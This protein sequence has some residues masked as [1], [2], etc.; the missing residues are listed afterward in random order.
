MSPTRPPPQSHAS[1]FPVL[2]W[3][4]SPRWHDG[5]LMVR[6]LDRRRGRRRRPRGNER[7]GRVRAASAWA[8]RSTGCP[9]AGM[10]VTGHGTDSRR[11]PTEPRSRHADLSPV[12]ASHGWNEIVVDGRGNIYVNTINFD[13]ADFGEVLSSGKTPGLIARRHTRR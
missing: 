1:S 13:F 8:G 7:G 12:V 5:R 10:L 6:Q 9:T 4:E 3:R 2:L 11:S